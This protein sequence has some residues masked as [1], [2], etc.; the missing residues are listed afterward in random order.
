MTTFD[1][2]SLIVMNGCIAVELIENTQ[3]PWEIL[4]VA[5]LS[6]PSSNTTENTERQNIISTGW[7][8]HFLNSNIF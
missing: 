7:G 5:E 8:E 6:P 4:A 3:S 2:H 1:T